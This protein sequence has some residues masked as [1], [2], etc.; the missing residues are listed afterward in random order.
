MLRS[1]EPSGPAPSVPRRRFD[2]EPSPASVE[3]SS[4]ATRTGSGI[5]LD[6]R[7]GARVGPSPAFSGAATGRPTWDPSRPASGAAARIVS[8]SF[9]SLSPQIRHRFPRNSRRSAA[10]TRWG[11][12]SRSS[13]SAANSSARRSPPAISTATGSTTSRSALPGPRRPPAARRTDTSRSSTALPPDFRWA[14]PTP[15]IRAMPAFPEPRRRAMSSDSL[16]RRPTS[17]TTATTSWSWAPRARTRAARTRRE[18]SGSSGGAPTASRAR[19]ARSSS[20]ARSRTS[21]A[22]RKTPTCWAARSRRAR[23]RASAGSRPERPAK[24]SP[25]EL[26]PVPSS[27]ST[28]AISGSECRVART[29]AS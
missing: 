18:R 23:P 13:P 14:T 4:G 24:T 10:S 7:G 17:T 25:P 21:R 8:A 20:S 15:G 3:R 5:R 11:S 22:G 28:A 12:D 19:A 1:L 2:A 6:A 9:S 27:S 26:R 16:W 29:P